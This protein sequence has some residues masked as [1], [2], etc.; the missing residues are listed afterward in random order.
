[1]PDAPHRP[2]LSHPAAE[3]NA[4]GA[5]TEGTATGNPD[6]VVLQPPSSLDYYGD[7][8]WVSPPPERAQVRPPW[9]KRILGL[10]APQKYSPRDILRHAWHEHVLWPQ[11]WFHLLLFALLAF[12][13]WMNAM[14]Y[15]VAV[16]DDAYIT[17]RYSDHF[18]H[19]QGLVYNLGERVE[20]FTNFTWM[21][22][23]G[24]VIGLGGDPM[25]WAKA[26]GF[27][28]SLGAMLG[29]VHFGS[30][31]SRRRDPWNWMAAVPLA[32][33]AHF[34]HWSMMGLETQ[35]QVV[36]L[37]WTF[38]R[39]YQEIHDQRAWNL[40]PV[41]AALAAMT[42]IESLYYMTPL[43]AYSLVQ[44]ARG[45][46]DWRKFL[47]WGLWAAAI[48]VPYFVWKYTYFGDIAPNTYYAKKVYTDTHDRGIAH[49]LYWYLAQGDALRNLWLVPL[50]LV[51]LWPRPVGIL[52]L[53]PLVLNV[54]YVYY[55]NG[56]W[57][58]NL[59][60]LQVAAPFMGLLLLLGIRWVQ[61]TLH[62]WQETGRPPPAGRN[63]VFWLAAE[64]AVFGSWIWLL[65]FR[66]GPLFRGNAAASPKVWIIAFI[67]VIALI[68]MRWLSGW[69]LSHRSVFQGFGASGEGES[70]TE[71]QGAEAS[72][73]GLSPGEGCRRADGPGSASRGMC[74][75]WMGVE[76]ALFM[77]LGIMAI[78]FAP[79]IREL[80]S[81]FLNNIR[82]TFYDFG[83]SSTPPQTQV[84]AAHL[85]SYVL[86]F[87]IVAILGLGWVARFVSRGR[88]ARS[89]VRWPVYLGLA[90][91][92]ASYAHVQLGIGSVYIFDKN[93]SSYPR[94]ADALRWDTIRRT[95]HSG[96]S[97]PLQNVADWI[98]NNC[99]SNT[100]IFMSDIG[101]P[102]WLNPHISLIDVDGL[103][104]KV[105]AD[106]PSARG[107][108]KSAEEFVSESIEETKLRQPLSPQ[109]LNALE[110]EVRAAL[111]AAES[112]EP[113]ATLKTLLDERMRKAKLEKPL[114]EGV[115]LQAR[116]DGIR[117]YH[118]ARWKR[119]AR[120]VLQRQPE[121]MNIFL[122]HSNQNDPKSTGWP[123][124]DIS[125]EVYNSPEFKE[126]YVEM[127]AL[128]KYF[129]SWNHFFRRK[130]VPVGIS[131]EEK[132]LRLTAG[133]RRNPRMSYLYL[134]LAEALVKA[135]APYEGEPRDLLHR[136]VSRFRGNDQFLNR[137]AQWGVQ[138]KDEVLAVEAWKASLQANPRQDWLFRQICGFYIGKDEF[139]N[140]IDVARTA[141]ES[142]YYR[143][144]AHLLGLLTRI[145]E[146]AKES[147]R[148][149]LAD[150]VWKLV[151][152]ATPDQDWIYRGAA[153]YYMAEGRLDDAI[154]AIEAGIE[155]AA[156]TSLDLHLAY[157]L[158][159]AG[160][161]DEA[162]SVLLAAAE[163]D[164]HR[165][166]RDYL[167]LGALRGRHNRLEA[168]LE[169]YRTVL[170]IDP[171]NIQARDAVADL[172]KRLGVA[173]SESSTLRSLGPPGALPTPKPTPVYTTGTL[174]SV[175]LPARKTPAPVAAPDTPTTDRSTAAV[176]TP[177]LAVVP[178]KPAPVPTKSAPAKPTPF[179]HGSPETRYGDG[180]T[181]PK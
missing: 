7:E 159:Q 25:F 69:N 169:A 135:G 24:V 73:C 12:A 81:V 19:G 43:A 59:R 148:T 146:K 173:G 10:P 23:L 103:T 39:F 45:R 106:A 35:L 136:A 151:L 6:D 58:P 167:D 180:S 85:S 61:Q 172:E 156:G 27:A 139:E 119:A 174:P 128:N 66:A 28:C 29:V 76:W 42:R 100:T 26:L 181:G 161:I 86:F 126:N 131:P 78:L 49:I 84:E 137:L 155:H 8:E 158:E 56:D 130:D 74:I 30:L 108:N 179:F 163:K 94:A 80:I 138:Q 175:P 77:A 36:L 65:F 4:E 96:F 171:R 40:S 79:A 150:A 89:L 140:A 83:L 17:F 98:L 41:L 57:M 102:L 21:A 11:A 123:Y 122:T 22:L 92:L 104:N 5:S 15:W 133:V 118:D 170:Q 129:A 176:P 107:K 116:A 67:S 143:G 127:E 142:S 72:R 38:A 44:V 157:L 168:A 14:G 70:A 111:P 47:R 149:D 46:L 112:E 90:M 68:L 48:F 105:V 120:Y 93:P 114:P 166:A 3:E 121:Y 2:S 177:R 34:A 55:V 141:I 153:D 82:I 125:K 88:L 9:W 134:D 18:I 115:L 160:R 113:N 124:P 64:I 109:E 20:G 33:S 13:F 164:H 132:V 1:V 87:L 162:E 165:N 117:R 154:R 144:D 60:F 52:I 152:Q 145:P 53:G 37:V 147:G 32:A 63:G 97:P 110:A 75:A 54:F 178:P 51:L 31:F 50:L 99:Q 62:D 71:V 95:M 101:Y 91:L 16:I